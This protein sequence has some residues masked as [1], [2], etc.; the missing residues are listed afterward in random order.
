MNANRRPVR[1]VTVSMARINTSVN[2]IL[3]GLALT[4]KQVHLRHVLITDF[5]A[6]YNVCKFNIYSIATRLPR[7]TFISWLYTMFNVVSLSIRPKYMYM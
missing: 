3:G 4:V 5:D 6:V 1:M 7:S 2:V